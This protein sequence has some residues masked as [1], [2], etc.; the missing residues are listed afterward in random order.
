[1]KLYR[2]ISGVI[3][4]FSSS[5]FAQVALD[6]KAEKAL[7]EI[8]K[9]QEFYWNKGDI[10]GFMEGY[11][12]N[13]ELVFVGKNGPTYGYQ[14]TLGNYK[15]GYPDKASMGQLHFD[16]LHTQQWDENTIQ[17]IGKYTLTRE[18]DQPTGYFTLLFRKIDSVW[19]IVSDHSSS[20]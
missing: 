17:L 6:S 4:F 20:S 14:N 13:A 9:A 19:K 3:L 7:S 10:E 2:T 1:M 5:V 12:N 15:K 11:W 18:N 16:I 8:M